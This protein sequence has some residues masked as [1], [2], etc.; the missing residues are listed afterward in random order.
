MDTGG[1]RQRELLAAAHVDRPPH[2]CEISES[3]SAIS[4]IGNELRLISHRRSAIR[5]GESGESRSCRTDWRTQFCLAAQ[6]T[7]RKTP[8]TT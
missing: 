8:K 5:S 2:D 4:V 6:S 3:V 1:D 7:K